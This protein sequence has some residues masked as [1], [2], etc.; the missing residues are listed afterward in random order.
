[1]LASHWWKSNKNGKC[2]S[3]PWPATVCRRW[4]HRAI[5]INIQFI[6]IQQSFLLQSWRLEKK[7]CDAFRGL[8]LW[9]TISGSFK[10]TT[11]STSEP[12]KPFFI[13]VGIHINIRLS[14]HRTKM[15]VKSSSQEWGLKNV[16]NWLV[17]NNGR[18]LST[19]TSANFTSHTAKLFPF[20]L[21]LLRVSV[22]D[23]LLCCYCCWV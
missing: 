2:S 21:A 15:C 8:E 6:S 18:V 23:L 3:D 16:S 14:E 20:Y 9:I 11:A 7:E 5:N 13:I 22:G 17:I 1:M 10:F 19:F 12:F 4:P